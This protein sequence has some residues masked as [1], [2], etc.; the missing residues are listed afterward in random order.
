MFYYA[1]GSSAIEAYWKSVA[2]PGEGLFVGEPLAQP[3]APRLREVDAGRYELQIFS[4]REKRLWVERSLSA[5]GPFKPL[6]R[7]TL[8]RRGINIVRF[9]FVEADGYLRLRW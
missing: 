7:Q 4:P 1:L 5:A 3:F 8:L 6:A 9:N 2:W